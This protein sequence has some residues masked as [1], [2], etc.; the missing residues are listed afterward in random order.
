MGARSDHDLFKAWFPSHGSLDE[1]DHALVEHPERAGWISV[2]SGGGP[3]WAAVTSKTLGTAK[4]LDPEAFDADAQAL[5]A[6]CMVGGWGVQRFLR[7]SMQHGSRR[8][9][10]LLNVE[11]AIRHLDGRL[12][13]LASDKQ[14][15]FVEG[16]L[17]S[18][19]V[20]CALEREARTALDGLLTKDQAA[21]LIP[22][23]QSCPKHPRRSY[24]DGSAPNDWGNEY[25]G[26]VGPD[27]PDG[28]S[29]W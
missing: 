1:R 15:A 22:R 10:A 29:P 18:R 3:F 9:K 11:K 14:V 16:L 13:A 23:L 6:S 21:S 19:I 24:V 4:A 5:T 26:F 20:E 7:A 2:S 28:Y 8:F 27:S 17:G 12:A 25:G